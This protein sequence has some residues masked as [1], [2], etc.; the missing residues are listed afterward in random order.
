MDGAKFWGKGGKFGEFDSGEPG[1]CERV[2][3]V[4]GNAWELG[5]FWMREIGGI[6]G[7]E[8]GGRFGGN[9]GKSKIRGN[10][11]ELRE[12]KMMEG[13]GETVG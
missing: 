7:I 2:G 6:G 8:Y 5:D 13:L 12:F 10:M 1:E 3:V 9:L 11:G 4:G